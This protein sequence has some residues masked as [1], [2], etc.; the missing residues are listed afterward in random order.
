M[1]NLSWS[2]ALRSLTRFASHN[3]VVANEESDLSIRLRE[4]DV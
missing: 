2:G 3:W 4:I 1:I